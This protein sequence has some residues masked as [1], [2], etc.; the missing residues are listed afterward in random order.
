ML[1]HRNLFFTEATKNILFSRNF[2][3]EHKISRCISRYFFNI[4]K[5]FEIYFLLMGASTP[6]SQS[7]FPIDVPSNLY[8]LSL[9]H[10]RGNSVQPVNCKIWFSLTADTYTF[11]KGHTYHFDAEAGASPVLKKAF[12]FLEQYFLPGGT[13]IPSCLKILKFKPIYSSH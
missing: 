2:M 1:E 6:V 7:G 8:Y 12:F 11:N 10:T 5:H 3:N 13:R 9:A 4:F